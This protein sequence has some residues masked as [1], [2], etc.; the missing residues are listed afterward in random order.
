MNFPS[1]IGAAKH[2]KDEQTSGSG[3][4]GD[5]NDAAQRKKLKKHAKQVEKQDEK[6]QKKTLDEGLNLLRSTA[7]SES[8]INTLKSVIRNQAHWS[9]T[10]TCKQYDVA[11]KCCEIIIDNYPERLGKEDDE[12]SMLSSLKELQSTADMITKHGEGYDFYAR[13]VAQHVV[14]VTQR[15]IKAS[16][17]MEETDLSVIDQH[18]HYRQS[19]RPLAFEFVG[20][21]SGHSFLNKA[22]R[23]I[24]ST[25]RQKILKELTTFKT[26]L[27]VED[28]SSIF[29][30]AMESRMDLLRVM[31]TGPSKTPYSCG[32]FCFDIYLDQ[33]PSKP[34]KVK[35]LTTGGGRYRF[36]PNL[37]NDGKVCLSLLGTW[38]GPGW[39]SGESTLLQILVSIQ[40]LILVDEPHFNEPGYQSS[41][42]TPRGQQLSRSYNANIRRYTLDAAILPYI[43]QNTLFPEFKAV[44]DKHFSLKQHEL[45]KQLYQWYSESYNLHETDPR[46]NLKSPHKSPSGPSMNV[47]YTTF[48]DQ[49]ESHFDKKRKA[50]K[51]TASAM[52][53]A[54][55]SNSNTNIR[56]KNSIIEIDD[57]DDDDEILQMTLL[58]SASDQVI[59]IDTDLMN[60]KL[61]AQLKKDESQVIDLT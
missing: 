14:V 49:A 27:P 42:G 23:C 40:S 46:R 54:S 37:Y 21:L 51:N 56:E 43:K 41:L 4:A 6:N 52:T 26:A 19:L 29:I 45:K 33:Y 11:I 7:P 13:N 28:G 2:K 53:W 5:R 57:N 47:L 8:L 1:L 17:N 34:P 3:Y 18:A 36:N 50:R 15:A 44:I 12:D 38:Q 61:P 24:S 22:N 58:A 31:I 10:T 20:E 39:V 55:I 16:R 59:E 30:R 60:K 48:L 32:C 25:Q 9:S 35:F